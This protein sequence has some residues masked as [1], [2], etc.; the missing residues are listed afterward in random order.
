[1]KMKKAILVLFLVSLLSLTFPL[2][3]A[4]GEDIPANP[5]SLIGS[6]IGGQYGVTQ[7]KL[8]WHDNSD[9]ENYF[10]IERRSPKGVYREIALVEENTKKFVDS[11]VSQEYGDYFYRVRAFNNA[12]YSEYSNEIVVSI[13]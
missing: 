1:M 3:V 2:V 6:R 11:E 5:D 13:R 12:G 9:N 10:S 8:H 7:I 4:G